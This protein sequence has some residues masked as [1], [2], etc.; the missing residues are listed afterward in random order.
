[1][2]ATMCNIITKLCHCVTFEQPLA[3]TVFLPQEHQSHSYPYN[4][5]GQTNWSKL[6][7]H[8]SLTNSLSFCHPLW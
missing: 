4:R 6:H 8:N 3:S 1:M 2:H 7:M 5:T